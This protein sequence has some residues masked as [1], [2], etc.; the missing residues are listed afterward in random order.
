MGI[1]KVGCTNNAKI[2]VQN[3]KKQIKQQTITLKDIIQSPS[4]ELLEKR[5]YMQSDEFLNDSHNVEMFKYGDQLFELR[6]RIKD[7]ISEFNKNNPHEKPYDAERVQGING[8]TRIK[9][10]LDINKPMNF[11]EYQSFY[12]SEDCA[13]SMLRTRIKNTARATKN[14]FGIKW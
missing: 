1:T 9:K 12:T 2:A 5:T 10:Y 8:F 6:N 13:Y 7:K 4:K 14:K 3:I 11:S